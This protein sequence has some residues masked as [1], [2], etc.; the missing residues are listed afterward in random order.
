MRLFAK[1]AVG[2]KSRFWYFMH[3]YH[4]MKKTTG[5]ILSVNEIFEKNPR[6]VNNYGIWLRY[7]SR[8][9][10][11]NM[12]KEFRDTTLCGAVEQ[13]YTE[14]AG[15]HRTRAQALQI[16]RTGIVK[17]KDVKRVSLLDFTTGTAKFPLPHKVQRAQ[18]RK[19]RSTFNA[20]RPTTFFN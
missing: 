12:Y 11:H 20:N 16:I 4:K 15:R 17:S 18:S 3:Q 8:T 1:N 19:V 5:E 6:I 14:M 2:A 9:G 13:L 7:N 10:T